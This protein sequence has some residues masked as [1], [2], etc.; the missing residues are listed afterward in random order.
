MKWGDGWAP[1]LDS[2]EKMKR[3]RETLDQL[4]EQAGRDPASIELAAF[5]MTGA[6]KDPRVVR[7]LEEAGVNRVTIRLV[8]TQQEDSA[9]AELDELARQFLD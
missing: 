2:V 1:H 7:E 5:G 4:A 6:L 9:L 3:G 8:R